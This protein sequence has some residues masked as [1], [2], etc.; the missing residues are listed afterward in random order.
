MNF[1]SLHIILVD[2]VDFFSYTDLSGPMSRFFCQKSIH[3]GKITKNDI[4]SKM[5]IKSTKRHGIK[6]ALKWLSRIFRE[7]IFHFQEIKN[8]RFYIFVKIQKA[9]IFKT[10]VI[11]VVKTYLNIWNAKCQVNISLGRI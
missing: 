3:V 9:Q 1:N 4:Y 5:Q 6:S 8:L 2:F 10:P 7:I 11:Y